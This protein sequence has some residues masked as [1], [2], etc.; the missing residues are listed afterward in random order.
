MI[1]IRCYYKIPK[2]LQCLFPSSTEFREWKY[3][4]YNSRIPVSFS[5]LRQDEKWPVLNRR[6][7][8]GTGSGLVE[9]SERKISRI[10]LEKTRP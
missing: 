10:F 5:G 7:L 2:V 8:D 9:C 6:V 1:F 4:I 3:K